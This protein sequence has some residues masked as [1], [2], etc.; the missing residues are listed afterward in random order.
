MNLRELADVHRALSSETRLRILRMLAGRPMCVNA[1]TRRLGISQPSVSQHLAVLSRAGLVRG[2]R[3]GS[4]VHYSLNDGELERL[5]RVL[6][7]LPYCGR[8]VDYHRD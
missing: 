2:S 7:R 8:G 3:E 4:R 6:S 5:S 1:I